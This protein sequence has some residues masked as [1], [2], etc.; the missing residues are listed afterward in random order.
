MIYDRPLRSVNV[1]YD[2]AFDSIETWAVL[3]TLRRL[4]GLPLCL[5]K[6]NTRSIDRRAANARF[7]CLQ[8]DSRSHSN[9]NIA[10]IHLLYGLATATLGL[11]L[12]NSEYHRR[13]EDV[14]CNR[15]FKK[16][17]VYILCTCAVCKNYMKKILRYVLYSLR[18]CFDFNFT[19]ERDAILRYTYFESEPSAVCGRRRRPG[20]AVSAVL[21]SLSSGKQSGVRRGASPPR[22]TSARRPWNMYEPTAAAAPRGVC[23]VPLDAPARPP[24]PAPLAPRCVSYPPLVLTPYSCNTSP[25]ANYLYGAYYSCA[26]RNL[27]KGARRPKCS[28]EELY[29]RLPSKEDLILHLTSSPPAAPP[30]RTYNGC[31]RLTY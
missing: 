2:R 25:L 14:D 1:L 18:G 13:I 30:A 16:N 24:G 9:S 21:C 26:H 7:D 19:S 5:Y 8:M 17:E 22:T 4:H 28:L 10:D 20:G 6:P 11:L 12:V 27:T 29:L 3:Q 15:K 23:D 31:P